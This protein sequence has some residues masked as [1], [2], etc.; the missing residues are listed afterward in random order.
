MTVI[1]PFVVAIRTALPLGQ[2][3]DLPAAAAEHLD[4]QGIPLGI[5]ADHFVLTV[6]QHGVSL[7]HNRR[8]EQMGAEGH[9]LYVHRVAVLIDAYKLFGGMPLDESDL[10]AARLQADL[11]VQTNAAHARRPAVMA[12]SDEAM[13]PVSAGH[14]GVAVGIGQG[15]A[16]HQ[17]GGA[18]LVQIIDASQLGELIVPHEPRVAVDLGGQ[19][20]A[21]T[22]GLVDEIVLKVG[23]RGGDAHAVVLQEAIQALGQAPL[24]DKAAMVHT[25]IEVGTVDVHV[26]FDALPQGGGYVLLRLKQVKAVIEHDEVVAVLAAVAELLGIQSRFLG[27][28]RTANAIYLKESKVIFTAEI[29]HEIIAGLFG[30]GGIAKAVGASPQTETDTALGGFIHHGAVA[31]GVLTAELGPLRVAVA[32]PCTVKVSGVPGI[33]LDLHAKFSFEPGEELQIR[34]GLG[35]GRALIGIIDPG[36]KLRNGGG[37]LICA[38]FGCNF[39]CHDD[40]PPYFSFSSNGLPPLSNIVI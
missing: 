27:T 25:R 5:L 33:D 38:R 28:K 19:D 26:G 15:K 22:K 12:G 13:I 4:L 20:H 9:E 36:K 40:R 35:L 32:T 23:H 11:T 39:L 10:L 3:R 24:K 18:S 16:I 6:L 29:H 21:S 31:V 30:L 1:T 8:L 17:D 14:G 7:A 37:A 34:D 2:Q